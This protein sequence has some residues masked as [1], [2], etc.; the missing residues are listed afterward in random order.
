MLF[1]YCSIEDSSTCYSC[2]RFNIVCTDNTSC[3][4]DYKRRTQTKCNHTMFDNILVTMLIF[5]VL[6]MYRNISN[7]IL[8]M[9]K[10]II[11][12]AIIGIAIAGLSIFG[13]SCVSQRTVRD[14]V[15][16][17]ALELNQVN[18]QLSQ[19]NNELLK[20]TAMLD[21][22]LPL[23]GQ[24]ETIIEVQERIVDNTDSLVIIN[25]N[26]LRMLHRVEWNTD[27]ILNIL[28]GDYPFFDDKF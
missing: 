2:E 21:S 16:Q 1:D 12:T 24:V 20:Q 19:A 11:L 3:F 25:N 9:K 5:H 8:T 26:M 28:R 22:L 7:T 10:K 17:H 27:T 13:T 4:F 15:A 6:R 18:N 23:V 14:L